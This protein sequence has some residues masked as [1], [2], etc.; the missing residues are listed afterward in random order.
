MSKLLIGIICFIVGTLA[1]VFC[2]AIVSSNG[3]DE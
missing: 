1:G 2:V 3:D